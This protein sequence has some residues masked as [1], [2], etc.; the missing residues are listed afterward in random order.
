MEQIGPQTNIS[1]V[2]SMEIKT[3]NKV[4]LDFYPLKLL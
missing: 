4:I 2:K 1:S 3:H